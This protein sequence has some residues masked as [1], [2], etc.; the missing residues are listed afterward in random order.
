MLVLPQLPSFARLGRTNAS[1]PTRS[2]TKSVGD[3]PEARH[4]TGVY[5]YSV[6]VDWKLPRSAR[7]YASLPPSSAKTSFKMPR[8]G[9]SRSPLV[10]WRILGFCRCLAYESA[11]VLIYGSVA[12]ID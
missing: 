1:V 11:A 2:K 8:A 6:F 7:R 3:G 5:V 10:R 9:D 12:Y 4:Y